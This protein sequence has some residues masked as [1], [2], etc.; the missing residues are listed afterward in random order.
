MVPYLS[1]FPDESANPL[2]V[3]IPGHCYVQWEPRR[4]DVWCE[5]RHNVWHTQKNRMWSRSRTTLP[6]FLLVTL[7]M[8]V[9][10]DSQILQDPDLFATENEDV[11]LKCAHKIS[12]YQFLIWYKHIPGRGLEIC[13]HGVSTA[14]NLIPRYS[15]TMDRAALTTELHITGVTGE[16]TAVYLLCSDRHTDTDTWQL[17]TRISLPISRSM[18]K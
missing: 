14:S 12:N 10:S 11:T 5:G 1:R 17:C 18:K 3:W 6:G 15:M 8:D 2:V 13:A 9:Q 7:I 4:A 16:D